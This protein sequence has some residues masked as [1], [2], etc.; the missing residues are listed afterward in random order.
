MLKTGMSVFML[1]VLLTALSACELFKPIQKSGQSGDTKKEELDPIQGRRV[2]D[3]LTGTYVLVRN[4]PSGSMDTVRWKDIP[5]TV[6]PPIYSTS[7]PVAPGPTVNPVRPIGV[8]EGNSQLLSSYN[9][10]MVLPFL[11]D[12]FTGD[13]SAIPANSEWA[14]QFYNGA[15]MA[16]DD[17]SA[18]GVSLNVSVL[19]SRANERQV[20]DL[21]RVNSDVNSAHL[22]IGPYTRTNVAVMAEKAK[23]NGSILVSPNSAASNISANNPNY[24]QVKPTLESHCQAIMQHVQK[25]TKHDQIVLVA[26]N[27]PSE[28][29]RFEF[30]QREYDR[31]T[32]L[33]NKQPLQ[34]I[35]V[36]SARLD[37][38]GIN[39][40]T[41][42]NSNG[43]T[44]FIV[45]SWSQEVFIY[46]F[47]RKLDAAKGQYQQVE[48]YG[49]PQWM[50]YEIIDFDFY[51]RLSVHV[52]SSAY[53]D[54]LDPD[55][56]AFKR[57]YYDTFGDLPRE[58]AF[59]GYDLTRYFGKMMHTYGT[60]FQY[61]LPENAEQMLH[62]RFA[63]QSIILPATTGT[64]FRP[65]ERWENK[66][67]NI[68][69]FKDYRFNKVN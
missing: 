48:V 2:Y 57:K 53:V 28:T 37:M 63:F 39:L 16:F 23:S 6:E 42:M 58:E 13:K 1:F 5:S 18:G 10:A 54:D 50:D 56:R 35:T 15:R 4:A 29:A 62:T 47:L 44:V 12:R 65:V 60:R 9:V 68:L 61:K 22:I 46:N 25:D 3:P 19:D 51:E 45:P 30:L 40:N 20:S 33:Q 67:V 8:G 14:L 24:I 21:A 27:T 55:V 66:H 17:L 38:S 7:A 36:D 64:E 69:R 31:L 43:K 32:G 52:S 26:L 11:S 49:M 59:V 41:Y 34:R